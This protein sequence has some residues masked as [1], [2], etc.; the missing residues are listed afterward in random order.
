[1]R[2]AKRPTVMVADGY[3]DTRSLL[4]FWLES[5]GYGVV[6]AGDGQVAFELTC[7]QCPD[8]ILMSERMPVLGGVEASRLI[9]QRGKGCVFPI[10]VMSSYPTKEA[11][12]AALAAGCDSFIPQPVNFD[13]LSDLLRR[14]LPGAAGGQPRD[15]S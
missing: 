13:L 11:R 8:L 4:R 14:L 3:E 6:E 7:G 5:E 9:R 2:E 12:D 15:G 1:M 10:V